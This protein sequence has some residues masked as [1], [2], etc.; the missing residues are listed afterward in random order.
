MTV[1]H[2]GGHKR[3]HRTYTPLEL[4][5]VLGLG[6]STIYKMLKVGQLRSVRAG[7]RIVIPHDSVEHFLKEPR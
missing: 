5:A 6:R 4:V 7:R 1:H 3:A 2:A